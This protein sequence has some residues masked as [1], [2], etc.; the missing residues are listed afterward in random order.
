MNK[1]IDKQINKYNLILGKIREQLKKKI[2][3][4]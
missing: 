1:W 3:G 4:K 2:I